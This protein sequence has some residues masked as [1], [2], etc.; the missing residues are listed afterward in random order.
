LQK[1]YIMLK[2][3]IRV[4]FCSVYIRVNITKLKYVIVHTIPD[5]ELF[6]NTENVTCDVKVLLN[7]STHD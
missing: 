3:T 2:Q 5:H 7:L 4:V 6:K 1:L